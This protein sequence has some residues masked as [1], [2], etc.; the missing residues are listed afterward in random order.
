VSK[1]WGIDQTLQLAV[2]AI[3]IAAIVVST[4][5]S[6]TLQ[7]QLLSANKQALVDQGKSV[8]IAYLARVEDEAHGLLKMYREDKYQRTFVATADLDASTSDDGALLTAGAKAS[9]LEDLE[10]FDG[11]VVNIFRAGAGPHGTLT[12]FQYRS[13]CHAASYAAG[14]VTDLGRIVVGAR[15]FDYNRQLF[16]MCTHA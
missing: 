5:S 8:A 12:P 11:Q 6:C 4:V 13:A 9:T 15:P 1:K 14:V 16:A 7:H 10:G 3:A 2:A